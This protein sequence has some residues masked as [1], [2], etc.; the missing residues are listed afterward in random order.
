MAPF[1][2]S[3][4]PYTPTLILRRP[5]GDFPKLFEN[6]D[7]LSPPGQF[8]AGSLVVTPPTRSKNR[9][10]TSKGELPV[11]GRAIHQIPTRDQHKTHW[12]PWTSPRPHSLVR[13]NTSDQSN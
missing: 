11:E 3:K 4:P 13:W 2:G 8:P 9:T 7:S 5:S 10:R 12:K 6:G 1:R